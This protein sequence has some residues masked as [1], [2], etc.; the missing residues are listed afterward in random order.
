MVIRSMELVVGHI[1]CAPLHV[2][3]RSKADVMPSPN[4]FHANVMLLVQHGLSLQLGGDLRVG[5][6]I[7]DHGS[8]D[9]P[10]DET[11]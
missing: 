5:C 9:K 4:A 8:V 10:S 2:H 11:V 3:F 7:A 6:Q 1:D